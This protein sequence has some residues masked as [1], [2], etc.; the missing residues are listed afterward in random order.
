MSDLILE[1][2]DKDRFV[3]RSEQDYEGDCWYLLPD[4]KS[5]NYLHTYS[6]YEAA[7][8]ELDKFN[9]L[10]MKC[11]DCEGRYDRLKID[12]VAN[13]HKG[14]ITVPDIILL[15]CVF[16]GDECFP[17]E[18]SKKIDDFIYNTKELT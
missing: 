2:H 15:R 9:A 12:Y 16:C 1:P 4:L 10:D 3:V 6:S 17:S 8:A 13:T 5:S 7:K 18:E 11:F 14:K